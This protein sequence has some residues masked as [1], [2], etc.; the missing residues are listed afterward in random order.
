[1]RFGV[2]EKK[3]NEL[4]ARMEACGLKESDIEEAFIKGS[5]PG[6]QNVNKTSTSVYLKHIPTGSE[7]K[8][9][10][11]RSQLLN[12]FYARRQLCELL[13]SRSMGKASP[14]NAAAAKIRKQKNRRR[15][16]QT[17]Q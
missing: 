11:T 15:R 1:M 13:E 3:E 14:R 2:T 5:G 10:K 16:R 17:L 4:L 6:G 7:V 8:C 12:R 9:G